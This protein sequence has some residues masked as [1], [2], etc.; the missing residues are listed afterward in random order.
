[1]K[2]TAASR[3][4][5]VARSTSLPSSFMASAARAR[6]GPIA[7][8]TV[9]AR[10]RRVEAAHGTVGQGDGGHGHEISDGGLRG[11]LWRRR[12]IGASLRLPPATARHHPR[13]CRRASAMAPAWSAGM[14]VKPSNSPCARPASMN[15]PASVGSRARWAPTPAPAPVVPSRYRCR[16]RRTRRPESGPAGA[17][18]PAATRVAAAA[19][20]PRPG[21][22]RAPPA[23]LHTAHASASGAGRNAPAHER[24]DHGLLQQRL[25]HGSSA[26]PLASSLRP[27]PPAPPGSRGAARETG[28][29]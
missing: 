2:P 26:A 5:S 21:H 4:I 23:G 7:A 22:R 14:L 1:M 13:A 19:R 12:R 11:G 10:H 3:S 24:G 9:G 18:R 6:P 25:R 28:S 17:G 20:T 16:R 27:A 8:A 15:W 29:C